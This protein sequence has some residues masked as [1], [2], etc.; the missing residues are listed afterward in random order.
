MQSWEA[1]SAGR[2]VFLRLDRGDDL[3]DALAQ[4]LARH[5]VRDGVVL[6]TVA[7]F[8]RCR[9][10]QAQ[11]TGFPI[12]EEILELAGPVEVM[13]A[14]GVVASGQP[15]I[16]ATVADRRGHAYG[17]H[18]EPGSTVLYLAEVAIL[19]TVGTAMARRPS[20]DGVQQLGPEQG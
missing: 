19:E 18:L 9:L 2:V 16:H 15:H 11:G 14:S 8:E 3:L 10:H 1:R 12:E 4:A 13:Q 7:T 17:G 5:G 6:S 20:P